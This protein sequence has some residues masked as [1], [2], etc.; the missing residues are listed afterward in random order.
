M[1]RTTTQPL[2]RRTSC[3]FLLAAVFLAWGCSSKE[4]H[5]PLPAPPK[6]SL[7]VSFN[8]VQTD[9]SGLETAQ[10][11]VVEEDG[12]SKTLWA[13][14]V[15]D[16]VDGILGPEASSYSYDIVGPA[17]QTLLE[18]LGGDT[19]QLPGY[20]DLQ[21][22][23]FIDDR[24]NER[25]LRLVWTEQKDPCFYFDH[26][27]EG[28]VVSRPDWSVLERKN[29]SYVMETGSPTP[30]HAG[31]T[32]YV[33]GV[34]TMGT[35]IMVSGRYFKTHIQ[36]AT[37][38]IYVFADTQ[39]TV[40]DQGYDGS[41]FANINIYPGDRVAIKGTIGSHDGMVEFYP[42][43]GYF[44]SV[45]ERGEPVPTPHVFSSVDDVYASGYTY[46]GDL[47]RIN[48]LAI[49][50]E[51]PA[52]VW[53]AYGQKAND[54][55]AKTAA[56]V[57]SLELGIYPGS[58]IPG[59][60]VPAGAFDLVGVL[61]REEDDQGNVLC[62]LY[63]RGLYDINPL[64][65]PEMSGVQV[66]VYKA[67]DPE[68]AVPVMLD[69]LPQCL[70]DREG[71]GAE[72][73][74]TLDS[75][76]VPQVARDPKKWVYKIIA[77]DGRQ[78]FES[79]SF[80]Q[81]KSGLLYPDGEV[82]NSFFYPGMNLSL[83]YFLGDVAEIVLYPAGGGEGPQPGQAVHGQGVNLLVN[84]TNYPVN[85]EDLPEPDDQQHIPLAA[86]VPDAVMSLYTMDGSFS[87][88]QI[89]V[90]Y[91]YHLVSYSGG[92]EC[93]VTWE[94]LEAGQAQMT[95][96]VPSVVGVEG[97]NIEDLF[98]IEMIRKI[99]VDDGLQEQTFYWKDLPTVERDVGDGTTE[100]VVF[101]DDVL[102][103]AGLSQAEKALYDYY[104][105]A[106]DDFGTYFPYG[107]HHLVDMFF[108]PLTNR[109]Y[110]TADNPEMAAYGG[111]YSTKAILR[112]ELRPVPQ[113]DPSLHVEGLGWLSNPESAASCNGCHVKKG[114]VQIPVNCAQC[115]SGF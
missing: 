113:A 25:G 5:T 1:S 92:R 3:R 38:G 43:S 68:N 77:R 9:L 34:A 8:Q 4:D 70:Y 61:H 40:E 101:F 83:I 49:Q 33:E 51:D 47:V 109:G 11:S 19:N 32:V 96:G 103:A 106:A 27:E 26:L 21:Q 28:S 14:K 85:F 97:C 72:P 18:C 56:D 53:P 42:V 111:R 114:V 44:V 60:T 54:L 62:T 75:L 31:E 57:Q 37:G 64:P 102:D 20:E 76:I 23:F 45:L 50:A 63:P 90:L 15:S 84:E 69:A 46:V 115:H 82:V 7:S 93:T 100:E 41:T 74:V 80:D 105:W 88:D 66:S 55:M 71:E 30:V 52:S 58:G 67:D 107:H 35:G 73:A 65:E 91:D 36:D 98:T 6:I 110:V 81:L 112:I 94:A 59:S 39:A 29:C 24:A 104:L 13:I 48:G 2:Y 16:W 17:D 95:T 99:V 12:T 86:F 108:N 22:A 87:P 79:L 78:P 89:R 10:V